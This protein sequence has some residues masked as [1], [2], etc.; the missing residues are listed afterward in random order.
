MYGYV[1]I[2]SMYVCMY[3]RKEMNLDKRWLGRC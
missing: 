1:R 3:V 2:A